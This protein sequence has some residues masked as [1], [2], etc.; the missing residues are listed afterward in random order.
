MH[1]LLSPSTNPKLAVVDQLF[2]LLDRQPALW[3]AL[4][5][6]GRS[7]AFFLT[8][9]LAERMQMV[10]DLIEPRVTDREAV[11]ALRRQVVSFRRPC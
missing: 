2:A 11:A 6:L 9:S 3:S 4:S 5:S 8:D 1:P 7:K 10:L